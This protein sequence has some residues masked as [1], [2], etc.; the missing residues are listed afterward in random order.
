MNLVTPL[1]KR[2]ARDYVSRMVDDKVHCMLKAKE[3]E[4][5]LDGFS[6]V[7]KKVKD[8]GPLQ[9]RAMLGQAQCLCELDK[10]GEAIGILDKLREVYPNSGLTIDTCLYQS[11][12]YSQLAMAEPNGEKRFDMFNTAVNALKR[13]MKFERTAGGRT[14]LEVDVGKLLERKAEAEKKYGTEAKAD[15]YTGQAIAAYQTILLFKNPF[16][17][18]IGPHMQDAYNQCLPLLLETE[19]WDDALQDAEKY[20]KTFPNGKYVLNVRTYQTKARVG[21]GSLDGMPEE[22][23]GAGF[24]TDEEPGEN[25]ET[26]TREAAPD[27]EIG[28]V[29]ESA[30]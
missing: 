15:E 11:R 12:A 5:S 4:I 10:Y 8:V 21:G 30:E 19:K 27:D 14:K 23:P 13:A 17:E 7:V 18:G 3:Y 20:L 9:E 25:T 2:T 1:H 16:E 22:D 29:E 28:E 24:A 6:Q 26:A